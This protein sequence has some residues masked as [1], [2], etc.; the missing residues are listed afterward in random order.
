MSDLG[1]RGPSYL[2]LANPWRETQTNIRPTHVI[3]LVGKDLLELIAKGVDPRQIV[4]VDS[5]PQVRCFFLTK[6]P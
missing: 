1:V 4:A 6:P 3:D 2:V 5:D